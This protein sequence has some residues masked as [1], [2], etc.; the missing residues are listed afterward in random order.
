M[1]QKQEQQLQLVGS[2]QHTS[3]IF[4]YMT[5][6]H[7]DKGLVIVTIEDDFYGIHSKEKANKDRWTN[8]IDPIPVTILSK[9]FDLNILDEVNWDGIK[10]EFW[11]HF[12][13]GV[14]DMEPE[15]YSFITHSKFPL[16]RVM[17]YCSKK[18]TEGRLNEIQS[19][20]QKNRDWD[21]DY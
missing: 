20:K 15:F 6:C 2:L 5:H 4:H 18:R 17:E 19:L 16:K 14:G 21:Q 9:H 8:F 1:K 7:P 10:H 11:T 12:N 3:W 13:I